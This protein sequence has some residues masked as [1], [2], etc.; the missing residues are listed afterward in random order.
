MRQ[1][2][3][4]R[5]I[6]PFLG[7]FF[8]LVFSLKALCEIQK[9]FGSIVSSVQENIFHMFEQLLV[10]VIINLQHGRIYNSHI[11]SVLNGVVEEC[12]VHCFT[13]RIVSAE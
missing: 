8:F 13:H 1:T 2:I 3:I 10:D 6:S 4:H 11:H 7:N 9:P 5:S 12:G